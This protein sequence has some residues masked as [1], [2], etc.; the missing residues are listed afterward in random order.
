MNNRNAKIKFVAQASLPIIFTMVF[1]ALNDIGC[2]SAALTVSNGTAS[3]SPSPSVTASSVARSWSTVDTFSYGTSTA[4]VF[5]IAVSG[6]SVV[7]AVTG[8]ATGTVYHQITRLSSSGGAFATVDDFSSS[9][10]WTD[11]IAISGSGTIYAFGTNT[12]SNVA[13]VRTSLLSTPS[14]STADT[15][16]G[17][18]SIT[19]FAGSA[20]TSTGAY[21]VAPVGSVAVWT[22]INY[23]GSTR[24][25]SDS[26][27]LSSGYAAYPYGVATSGSTVYAVGYGKDS[28]STEHW[29]VRSNASGS[30]ATVDNYLPSGSVGAIAQSVTVASDGSIYVAGQIVSST[31]QQWIVR[32]SHDGGSTW[33]VDDSFSDYFNSYAQAITSDSTGVFVA[34]NAWQSGGTNNWVVR[35]KSSTTGTWSTIDALQGTANAIAALNGVLYVGGQVGSN[36]V[37][38]Q[39]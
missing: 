30:W 11:S 13:E 7:T 18:S 2:G 34:G 27:Q 12:N 8:I 24:T 10:N 28:G 25:V 39:Y 36:A 14:F 6:S 9:S 19:G 1:L 26:Y 23:T 22:T 21:A 38:R 31:T 3:P 35:M 16:S 33:T 29:V 20:G 37:V 5:G 15:L 32:V 17:L 4:S